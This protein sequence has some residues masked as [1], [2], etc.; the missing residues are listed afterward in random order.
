[1]DVGGA[2]AWSVGAGCCDGREVMDGM[3]NETGDAVFRFSLYVGFY[4]WRK[5]EL[6]KLVPM[7]FEAVRL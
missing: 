5:V 1:M 4:S 3:G 2:E 7:K 6:L